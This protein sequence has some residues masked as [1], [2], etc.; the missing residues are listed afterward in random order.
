M[1]GSQTRIGLWPP[2]PLH[3]RGQAGQPNLPF[4]LSDPRGRVFSLARHGLWHGVKALGLR[5]GDEI[6]APAYHQGAEIEA[7]FRA[8]LECRF[9]RVNHRL[10][11]VEEDL[12]RLLGPGSRALH[13][14]HYWGFPQD[15]SYWRAWCDSRGLELISDGAQAL[16]SSSEAGEAGSTSDLAVFCLYKSFGLPDGAA[17][18]CREPLPTPDLSAPLG[19]R[20]LGRRVGSALTAA[21]PALARLRA[22]LV[23]EYTVTRGDDA[24]APK[25]EIELGEP[26]RPPSIVSQRLL[27]RIVDPAAARKRRENFEVLLSRFHAHVPTPFD[28]LPAGAVPIAFPIEC[29]DVGELLGRLRRESIIGGVL[30]PTHHPRLPAGPWERAEFFGRHVAALPVHQE[31]TAG[32]LTRLIEVLD[33]ILHGGDRGQ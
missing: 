18:F 23:P 22:R 1:S 17:V 10:E 15:E 7:F 16:F 4:P 27:A 19:I 8:G 25:H 28:A 12:E 30:W 6:L 20:G 32:Q 31:L 29:E 13:I 3:G 26:T 21:S 9:Y 24:R 14:I 2:F 5:P 33:R 11:P